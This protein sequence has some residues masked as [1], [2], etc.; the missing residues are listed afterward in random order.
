MSSVPHDDQALLQHLGELARTVDPAPDLLYELGRMAF[1]TRRLDAELAALVEDHDELVAL[2]A[3][4]TGTRLVSFESGAAQIDL[5]LATGRS[6]ISLVGQ[7]QPPPA[8]AGATVSLEAAEVA[9]AAGPGLTAPL[10]TDGFFEFEKVPSGPFR[11]HFDHL[12]QG[13]VVTSW[14]NP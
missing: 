6:G 1:E 4:A 3:T 2:R 9:E 10:D 13:P 7:V 8:T 5:Q 14:I 12:P 11:L